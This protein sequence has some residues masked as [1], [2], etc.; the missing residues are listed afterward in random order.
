MTKLLNSLLLLGW[1]LCSAVCCICARRCPCHGTGSTAGPP[2]LVA[3]PARTQGCPRC[4]CCCCFRCSIATYSSF[5]ATACVCCTS[6]ASTCSSCSSHLR[7]LRLLQGPWQQWQLLGGVDALGLAT[8]QV[9]EPEGPKKGL[10][11]LLWPLT[12]QHKAKVNHQALGGT[13]HHAY[14]GSR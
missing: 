3:L 4:C 10:W 8:V 5:D 6:A 2:L 14:V 7:Q 13:T 11:Q 12:L 9:V 1:L